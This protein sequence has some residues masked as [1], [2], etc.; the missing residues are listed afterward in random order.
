MAYAPELSYRGSAILRRLAWFRGEPMTK[1]LEAL[2]DATGITMAAIRPAEVCARCKDNSTG[3][4]CAFRPT[5][6]K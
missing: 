3:E 2:L 4:E 5:G 1:T 6:K